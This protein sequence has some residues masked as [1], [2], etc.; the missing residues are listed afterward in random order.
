MNQA[1]KEREQKKEVSM[2]MKVKGNNLKRG[3]K[4]NIYAD[5]AVHQY[6]YFISLFN[7]LVLK[8]VLF[9]YQERNRLKKENT[10]FRI[11]QECVLY[12]I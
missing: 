5:I 6:R 7:I 11:T 9:P 4:K 1:R 8:D 12:T 3:K 2:V 10:L